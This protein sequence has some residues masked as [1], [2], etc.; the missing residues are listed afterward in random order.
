MVPEQVSHS[1]FIRIPIKMVPH[2]ISPRIHTIFKK[3]NR[4]PDVPLLPGV[5]HSSPLLM[6][7]PASYI[8][9]RTKEIG[10]H[11]QILKPVRK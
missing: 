2:M 10:T 4:S 5:S 6:F 7:S 8:T 3:M 11:H 1:F 9:L